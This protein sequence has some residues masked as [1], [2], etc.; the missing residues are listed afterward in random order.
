MFIIDVFIFYSG[1]RETMVMME[2]SNTVLNPDDWD[3]EEREEKDLNTALV[4]ARYNVSHI[5][6][7]AVNARGLVFIDWIIYE[8]NTCSIC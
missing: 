5:R 1:T 6:T 3:V 4:L 2:H 8:C 7:K